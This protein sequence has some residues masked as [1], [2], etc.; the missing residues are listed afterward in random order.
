MTGASGNLGVH[1]IERFSKYIKYELHTYTQ[2]K[3]IKKYRNNKN[4]IKCRVD[5]FN[6]SELKNYLINNDI[7]LII[8]CAAMTNLDECEINKEK[9]KANFLLTKNS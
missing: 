7:N 9:S 8:H 1:L 6:Q 4:I 5:I 3:S 2:N